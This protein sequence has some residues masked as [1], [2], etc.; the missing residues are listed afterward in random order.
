MVDDGGGLGNRRYN[1]QVSRRALLLPLVV[2]LFAGSVV[3]ASRAAVVPPGAAELFQHVSALTAP[4]MEGRASG[5]AGGDRAA[6]YIADRLAATGLAP[7]GDTGTFFQSFVVSTPT[8]VA[9]GTTLERRGPEQRLELGRDWTPHGGSLAAEVSGEIVFVGYGVVAADRGWDDYAGVSVRDKIALALE[10]APGH[11]GDVPPP[12]LEKLIAARRHG[13]RALLLVGDGLPPL[14]TTAAAVR[15]VSG[16]ITATAAD[17]LLEPS[18]KTTAQLR[19]AL[20]DSRAPVSF[21]TGV[22]LRMRVNFTREDRRA[23]NVIGLLPGTDPGRASEALVVGAHYDHL[24]RAGG[25]VHPGAD[26]NASGTALVLGLA[27]ALAAA[28]GTPRTVVF[29]LFGGEEA[30]LLGSAHYVRHPTVPIDRTIAMLN[31]DMVGRMRDRRL[32]VG[33]V[34]S[35][36]GFR[37]LLSASATGDDL[38]LVLHDSPFAASD[39]VSFYGA[40]APVL[41]FSTDGHDDY[42]TPRDTADKID[43]AGMAEVAALAARLVDHLGGVTRP[44]YVKLSPPEKNSPGSGASGSTFLGVSA[45]A[46]DESDG[47][48]LASVLSDTA[49]AR[50]GLR[51]G[52]VIVRLGDQLINGFDDLK[53]TIERKQPGDAVLVLYL[54]DGEDHVTSA[55]LGARP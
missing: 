48:R 29:A 6:R 9:P 36:T 41:F 39:H 44:T 22:E 42:H 23:A 53:R 3:A 16:A 25:A 19:A 38:K 18:G 52:D 20:A 12:R 8:A 43:A 47:L 11:L 37:A 40:G 5:S 35:G 55:T 4:E 33:G 7:G 24:G 10:G 45:D 17:L 34:Q 49:A 2:L 14:G 31:F 27:R 13:A 32:N 21:A 26:D 28:G 50:A 30:G 1:G 54:R 51:S 46:R 15:L